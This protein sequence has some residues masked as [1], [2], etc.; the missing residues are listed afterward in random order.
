[1][2]VDGELGVIFLSAG[3]DNSAFNLFEMLLSGFSL[4]FGFG[5]CINAFASLFVFKFLLRFSFISLSFLRSDLLKSLFSFTFTFSLA[6]S[7]SESSSVP[8]VS[9]PSS[10]DGWDLTGLQ[11]CCDGESTSLPSLSSLYAF[12]IILSLCGCLGGV[13]NNA[14]LLFVALFKGS[15]SIFLLLATALRLNFDGVMEKFSMTFV[16]APVVP[17]VPIVPIP[18][19]PLPP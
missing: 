19:P 3:V 16:V 15:C 9:S 18:N 1:M 11:G 2:I 4:C 12:V 13:S 14:M 7:L 8:S 5:V 6:L 17:A 10:C